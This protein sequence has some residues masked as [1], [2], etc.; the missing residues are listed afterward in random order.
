MADDTSAA[1]SDSTNSGSGEPE[2]SIEGFNVEFSFKVAL[3]PPTP[4]RSAASPPKGS[5]AV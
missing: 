3:T 4:P 2:Y 5:G 1:S